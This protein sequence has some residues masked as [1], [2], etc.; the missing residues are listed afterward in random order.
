MGF[1]KY[2]NENNEIDVTKSEIK[3]VS[4]LLEKD[5]DSINDLDKLY[6]SIIKEDTKSTKAMLR[7]ITE[8]DIK[9]YLNGLNMTMLFV[10][11]EHLEKIDTWTGYNL[12]KVASNMLK[13]KP[14]I[15]EL[16]SESLKDKDLPL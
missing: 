11:S 4:E 9:E 6:V 3:T 5:F 15:Q 16:V 1:K 14:N 10:I 8:S 7:D 12:T 2:I 13:N